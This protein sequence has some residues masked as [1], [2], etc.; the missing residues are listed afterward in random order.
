MLLRHALR[1]LPRQLLTTSCEQILLGSERD[2]FPSAGL[3]VVHP[4]SRRRRL[5]LIW[6][7]GELYQP[8]P[9]KLHGSHFSLG[10]KHSPL[11]YALKLKLQLRSYE[12]PIAIVRMSDRCY[13]VQRGSHFGL[14]SRL[15]W[16]PG[17]YFSLCRN[18]SPLESWNVESFRPVTQ[19]FPTNLGFHG[20][21][22]LPA[23][24]SYLTVNPAECMCKHISWWNE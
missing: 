1:S 20:Y 9:K 14:K 7:P 10:R 18:D 16:L 2:L 15:K 23:W 19:A 5:P 24:L 17:S 22:F 8:R 6:L 12:R 4:P 11:F 3:L 13:L 21:L